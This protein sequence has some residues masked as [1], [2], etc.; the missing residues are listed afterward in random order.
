MLFTYSF[1]NVYQI[2]GGRSDLSID[3][4]F[5][6]PPVTMR[7]AI[8]SP[9][10][11]PP[12]P[13]S[14]LLIIHSFLRCAHTFHHFDESHTARFLLWNNWPCALLFFFIYCF[15]VSL[16]FKTLLANAFFLSSTSFFSS[17]FNW[18]PINSN[19]FSFETFSFLLFR[20]FFRF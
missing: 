17:T 13:S 9:S 7:C 4:S 19:S 16:C 8:H 6:I 20:C 18:L 5:F 2:C 15:A 3:E 10:S 1:S 14:L 11:S 12:P